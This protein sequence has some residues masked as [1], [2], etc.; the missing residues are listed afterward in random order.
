MATTAHH[1]HPVERR[2]AVVTTTDQI[3]R[4]IRARPTRG[5]VGLQLTGL[6][7]QPAPVRT[8]AAETLVIRPAPGYRPQ[9][10]AAL[11]THRRQPPATQT[12]TG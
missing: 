6:P 1:P 2:L 9:V 8:I 12:Q 7:A 5:A 11:H 10:R 4:Q 3:N